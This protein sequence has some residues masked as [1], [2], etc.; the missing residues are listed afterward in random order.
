MTAITNT[1][2]SPT[3]GPTSTSWWVAA[4]AGLTSLI[5][6]VWVMV[7]HAPPTS[8]QVSAIVAVVGIIVAGVTKVWHDVQRHQIAA[9]LKDAGAAANA[10]KAAASN[11]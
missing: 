7:N 4:S 9:A 11:P 3:T 5:P 1:P 2:E 8:Q 6:F 10:A